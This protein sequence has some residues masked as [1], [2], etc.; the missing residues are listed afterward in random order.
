MNGGVVVYEIESLT[1]LKI[2][3]GCKENKTLLKGKNKRAGSKIM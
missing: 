3:G 1:K 2:G